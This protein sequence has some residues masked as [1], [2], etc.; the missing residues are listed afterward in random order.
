MLSPTSCT[1][2]ERPGAPRRSSGTADTRIQSRPP[3]V[4]DASS[5]QVE[6][7]P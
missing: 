6:A 3:A 1:A 5:D 7:D 4:V 2:R